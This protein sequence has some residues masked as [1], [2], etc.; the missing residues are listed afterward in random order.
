[1]WHATDL[2]SSVLHA[3]VAAARAAARRASLIM[4]SARLQSLDVQPLVVIWGRWQRDLQ[5]DA[6]VVDG[7]QVL[8][9][10]HLRHWLAQ[11]SSGALSADHAGEVLA[12]L[13]Q[14]KARVD[15]ARPPRT[16]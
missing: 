7:V 2:T 1:K 5:E 8:K 6:H 4:R 15:P 13:R 9:G 3:D 16:N 10:L 14:F 11:R 12:K